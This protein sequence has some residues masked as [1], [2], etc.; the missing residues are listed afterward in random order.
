MIFVQE[1]KFQYNVV[2]ESCSKGLFV[3]LYVKLSRQPFVDSNTIDARYVLLNV[4]ASSL[5]TA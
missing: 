2:A 3:A 4:R 1:A 5:S